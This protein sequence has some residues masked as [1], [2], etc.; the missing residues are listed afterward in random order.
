MQK[1]EKII[2]LLFIDLYIVFPYAKTNP[3]N[4]NKNNNKKQKPISHNVCVVFLRKKQTKQNKNQNTKKKKQ[5][6]KTHLSLLII[7]LCVVFLN[8]KPSV[9]QAKSKHVKVK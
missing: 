6:T 4:N 8:L 5:A 1:K 9:T 3:N 2:S 7:E